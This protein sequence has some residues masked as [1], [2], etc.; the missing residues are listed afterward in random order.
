MLITRS[1]DS[2]M[3]GR[4][5]AGDHTPVWSQVLEDFTSG[6]YEMNPERST[7]N[8]RYLISAKSDTPLSGGYQ[9]LD[10][11]T[12]RTGGVNSLAIVHP[13]HTYGGSNDVNIGRLWVR[14]KDYSEDVYYH[15][16]QQGKHARDAGNEEDWLPN[17]YNRVR[18]WLK[19]PEGINLPP[20]PGYA[21]V[22]VGTY[23]RAT[24]GRTFGTQAQEEGGWHYY[25][26]F[27]AGYTGQWHQFIMD[28]HVQAIRDGHP[29]VSPI[30]SGTVIEGSTDYTGTDWEIGV[31]YFDQMTGFYIDYGSKLLDDSTLVFP[32]RLLIDEIEFYRE[33]NDEIEDQKVTSLNGVYNPS[34]NNLYVA[35]RG[36]QFNSDSTTHESVYSFSDIHTNGWGSAISLGTHPDAAHRDMRVDTTSIDMTGQDVIYV[37]VRPVGE[38]KFK[39]ISIPLTQTGRDIVVVEKRS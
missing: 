27:N 37:A 9:E 21:S 11:D 7:D 36:N 13:D 32:L 34:D 2:V 12:V 22:D 24:W 3:H 1:S 35:W 25:H 10:T 26:K 8:Y 6:L 31:N 16:R 18:F 20:Y 38:T 33:S 28:T 29:D 15:I 19:I 14:P 5:P 17:Y 30:G 23:T 39:Q 4:S